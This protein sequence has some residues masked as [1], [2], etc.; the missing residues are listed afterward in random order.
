MNM[1]KS[2]KRRWAMVLAVGLMV[3][4]FA[5]IPTCVF[6]ETSIVDSITLTGDISPTAGG[7]M[8]FATVPTDAE[9]TVMQVWMNDRTEKGFSDD[10]A[11]NQTIVEND[12]FMPE[13][14]RTFDADIVYY[15]IVWVK[16]SKDVTLAS[17]MQVSIATHGNMEFIGDDGEGGMMYRLG[18]CIDGDH[19]HVKASEYTSNE[20]SHW[21]E[22]VDGDGYLFDGTEE[23]HTFEGTS[24]YCCECQY[25]LPEVDRTT[26]TK[27]PAASPTVSCG[28]TLELKVEATGLNLKYYWQW[29]Y[30]GGSS[31]SFY[32]ADNFMCSGMNVSGC[33]TDTLKIEKCNLNLEKY[34]IICY[35][36]GSL[37]EAQ[38][39]DIQVTVEHKGAIYTPIDDTGHKVQCRCG[40]VMMETTP[41]IYGEEGKCTSCGYKKGDV[42]TRVKEMTLSLKD[43]STQN[44]AGEAMSSAILTGTG[45]KKTLPNKG[46]QK[47]VLKNG[48]LTP[49]DTASL[50]KDTTYTVQIY[51]DFEDNFY[52][53]N[54]EVVY[55]HYNGRTEAYTPKATLS[56]D[57][58]YYLEL[59]L[60]PYVR[61]EV[62]FLPNGGTGTQE[63]MYADELNHIYFPECTFTKSGDEFYAW[64]YNGKL[65]PA[66]PEKNTSY[67]MEDGATVEAVWK[68]QLTDEVT[69]RMGELKNGKKVSSVGFSV[70]RD[71]KYSIAGVQWY[72]WHEDVDPKIMGSEYG[73]A[74][75]GDH[76]L[77]KN[78]EYNVKVTV[79]GNGNGFA[80]DLKILLNSREMKDFKKQ[81]LEY[82]TF[83]IH[84]KGGVDMTVWEPI[85]GLPLMSVSDTPTNSKILS[86]DNDETHWTGIGYQLGKYPPDH[87]VEQGKQ[88][89]LSI[90]LKYH[91]DA[92]NCIMFGNTVS[93]NG[94]EYNIWHYG[95]NYVSLEVKFEAK[96]LYI[97]VTETSDGLIKVAV[98]QD[99]TLTFAVAHYDDNGCLQTLIMKDT[100]FTTG[101][102]TVNLATLD[103]EKAKNII[104]RKK[105]EPVKIMVF[106]NTNT[107]KPMIEAKDYKYWQSKTL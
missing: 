65:Y 60:S 42:K 48:I 76:A 103:M 22:C 12:S 30:T 102:N 72:Q 71:S 41:H 8:V 55:V 100:A 1:R 69:V 84:I 86:V 20:F 78:N 62:T 91:D 79:K 85:E 94:K 3:S 40:A 50:S 58:T 33:S 31:G 38:T 37:G 74:L 64:R 28:E 36:T 2:F 5:G 54:T 83:V 13:A 14:D 47:K 24:G 6:A 56:T 99:M 68:R 21:Y 25:L 11:F 9:Y 18:F 89:R 29:E 80:D 88:Y 67:Y 49:P 10:E 57:S 4:L 15:F 46:I 82:R 104:Y 98:P 101:E 93:V 87:K 19:L 16:P 81:G 95:E 97:T 51:P 53:D 35:V 106:E 63:T 90:W 52:M 23:Y 73:V 75:A 77:N 96:E 26:I 44:T 107:L 45:I 39:D 70:P 66:D 32:N 61:R 27:A 59:S 105:S 17:N 92:T 7:D 34:R 43:F